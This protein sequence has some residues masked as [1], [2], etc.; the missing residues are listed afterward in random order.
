MFIV[1][2]MFASTFIRNWKSTR[3]QVKASVEEHQQ[4]MAERQ[5]VFSGLRAW[6][7]TVMEEK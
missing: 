4:R 5:E 1:H 3:N 2:N 6:V 7:D